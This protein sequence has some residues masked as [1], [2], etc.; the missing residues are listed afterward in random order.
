M[1]TAQWTHRWALAGTLTLAF[2]LS[3]RASAQLGGEG[4]PDLSKIAGEISGTV[5]PKPSAG[6]KFSSGLTVPS[7][8][9]GAAARE[10]GKQLR[11]K[12][13]AA[14]GAKQPALAQLEAEMPKT[15][16]KLEGEL[17]KIGFAKRDLGVAVGYYF[18][19]TYEAATGKTVPTSA[20]EAAGRTVALAT[21]KQWGPRYKALPPAQQESIYEKLLISST[22]IHALTDQFGKAGKTAEAQGMRDAAGSTFQTVFG[23][24]AASIS[25]DESGKIVSAASAKNGT[26][27]TKT[28]A[29]K[30]EPAV[31]AGPIPAS[32]LG[33]AKIFIRYRMSYGNGVEVSLDQLLLFPDGTAF[34]DVPN[35]P[36][37]RFDLATVK[38]ASQ[39]GD[40][41]RWKVT[42]NQLALTFRGK[43]ETFRK[44]PSSG[45][46]AEPDYKDGSFRVYFPVVVATKQQLL[47]E[48]KHKSLFTMGTMGGGAPMVAA[49][50]N[51]N[52]TFSP[53][54]TFSKAGESFASATTANMGDAF[55]AGG[56][57][58]TN[59]GRKTGAK[60]QWRLDG[61]LLTTVENGQRR[62]QIAFILP[63]WGKPTDA[64]EILIQGDR[65]FRPGTD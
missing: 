16:E 60:G 57:V 24:P 61:P 45:G 36:L 48:W 9:P 20:S 22:L 39:P 18:V 6:K 55:K 25:I 8:T 50:S 10:I 52:L 34:N 32:D 64:P 3:G 4:L 29:K 27:A 19:M 15:L 58:T 65:Y 62:V 53:N 7:V 33:G 30:A 47:G 46:W 49:G 1:S 59:G 38:Q 37:P 44:H 26:L 51:S 54:G 28:V 5:A 17:E 31:K 35:D 41:G 12:T 21:A 56:D 14:S 2:A 42:G 63:K 11:E 13:E 23:V 43:T 40:I